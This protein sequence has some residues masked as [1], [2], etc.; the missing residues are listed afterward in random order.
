VQ[1][2]A[3][4]VSTSK[5]SNTPKTI[6]ASTSNGCERCYNIDINVLC[7]QNQHLNIKQVLVKSCDEAIGKEA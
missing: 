7:A 5:L 1:F 2:D 6:K 4:W 3:L